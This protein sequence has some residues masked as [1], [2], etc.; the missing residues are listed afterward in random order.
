MSKSKQIDEQLERAAVVIS[1]LPS[2]MKALQARRN[3]EYKAEVDRKGCDD[4][5]ERI[6]S[7]ELVC[8]GR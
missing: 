6:V 2:W 5:D 1:K 8:S 7:C 3:A 4:S